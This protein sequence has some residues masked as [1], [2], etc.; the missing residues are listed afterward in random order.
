MR[1]L[2]DFP[3]NFLKPKTLLCSEKAAI[4]P[5]NKVTID[6]RCAERQST[7]CRV[8]REKQQR[9]LFFPPKFYPDHFLVSSRPLPM[10]LDTRHS[11]LNFGLFP[12]HP[13]PVTLFF[14]CR[15]SIL[16]TLFCFHRHSVLDTC[17]SCK[18]KV[19]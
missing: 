14:S 19:Q 1:A 4:K 12:R 7:E 2:L 5:G 11:P 13:T 8:P 15:H 18:T 17:H 9:L 3:Q 10:G 16:D 6:E